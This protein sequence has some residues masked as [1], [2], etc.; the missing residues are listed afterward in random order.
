MLSQFSR[1]FLEE[2]NVNQELNLHEIAQQF[3]IN[4]RMLSSRFKELNLPLKKFYKSKRKEL[5][6][7]K[8]QFEEDY[9]FKK[10]SLK[11]LFE[12]WNLTRELFKK[13]LKVFNC[14]K[15]KR[16]SSNKID[17]SLFEVKKEELIEKLKSDTQT[18]EEISKELGISHPVFKN[19]LYHLNILK[20]NESISHFRYSKETSFGSS[21]QRKKYQET[22]L[23]KYGTPFV[24]LSSKSRSSKAEKEILLFCQEKLSDCS[25]QKDRDV[26]KSINKELDIFI[27]NHKLAIEHS[28]IFFHS[29]YHPQNTPFDHSEKFFVCKKQGIQLMTF[30]DFEFEEKKEIVFSMILAKCKKFESRVF[31]RECS[32]QEVD[33]SKAKMF[34]DENHIQG[35]Y[36]SAQAKVTIA[37]IKNNEPLG[38]MSF[39]EHHRKK[40]S[41]LVL[42]RCC[43]KK[44]VQVI[45]GSQK[46]FSWFKNNFNPKSIVS[47]SDNRF[48]WGNLYSLLGFSLEEDLKEDYFYLNILTGQRC[49]KQSLKKQK[50]K[51]LGCI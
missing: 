15:R 9:F 12:K 48:S 4:P 27:P 11:E 19:L 32:L 16:E 39:G 41:D 6:F 21:L 26:L 3:N 46:M 20:P 8:E 36:S 44:N 30:W 29:L 5:P 38:M 23:K 35:L 25:I 37:L 47:W 33:F 17:F 2:L 50:L 10:L 34:Y 24:P 40:T 31:G 1:E 18:T 43:F 13:T 28:G 42:T 45:G 51:H 14:S 22:C 49:S 7:S